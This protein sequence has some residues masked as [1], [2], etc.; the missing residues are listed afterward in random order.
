MQ[1]P[2]LNQSVT[3]VVADGVERMKH[4]YRASP[5]LHRELQ[6]QLYAS[7]NSAYESSVRMM[8]SVGEIG[9]HV[10]HVNVDRLYH[11]VSVIQKYLLTYRC[12]CR[13]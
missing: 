2:M 9:R 11:N 6:T 7:V 12:D 1:I 10:T 13:C 3:E 4:V 5:E 8:D